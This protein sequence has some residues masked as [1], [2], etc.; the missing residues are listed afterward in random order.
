MSIGTAGAIAVGLGAAGS[1]ASAA[2]GS[3]A[4]SNA[5]DAQTQSADAGIEEQQREFNQTQANQQPWIQAGQGALAQLTAGTQPGGALVQPYGQTYQ[6]PAPFTYTPFSAPTT[7]DETNDPGYQAR[8]AMGQQAMERAAS[9][10]GGA[11]SGGTLAAL[12]RYGQDYA[13]NEY[14]NV[15][16]RALAGYNTNFSD[17][18]NSYNTNT[19]NALNAY[20]T[21]YNVWSQGQGNQFNRLA[22]IAGLGQTATGQLSQAQQNLGTNITS[23]LTGQGNAQAAGILGGASAINSGL[24]GL[25]GIGSQAVGY[26]QNQ[27]LLNAIAKYL[28][29]GGAGGAGSGEG[30]QYNQIYTGGDYQLGDD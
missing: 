5:A 19:A 26:S 2:L 23:L 1:V 15:Y 6:A 21:N 25:T 18:L 3:S 8:M 29:G 12:T 24:A 30:S 20:N 14:Q 13:S 7:V 16:N 11:F 4:A 22:A 9:A 28:W 17:A 10:G 27:T